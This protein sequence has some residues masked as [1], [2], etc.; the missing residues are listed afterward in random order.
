[1]ATAYS[2]VNELFLGA[3]KDYNIDALYLSSTPT[4]ADEYI[5]VFMIRAIPNFDNCQQNLESRNDTTRTFSITLTTDEKVI[6]SN[7]MVVEWFKKETLDIRQM[8]LHLSDKD[9]KSY[10]EANNLKQ[11]TETMNS[12]REDTERLMLKYSQKYIDWDDYM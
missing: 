11:K 4:N 1:M 12:I 10:A 2:E 9:F 6:L 5:K 7:L 3:I 8:H